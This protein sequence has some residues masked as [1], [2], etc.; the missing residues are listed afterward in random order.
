MPKSMR[1]AIVKLLYKKNDHKNIENWR[2]VSL[3]NT[4]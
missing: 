4:D 3:L 2:P 1:E